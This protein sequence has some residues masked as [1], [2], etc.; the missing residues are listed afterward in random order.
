MRKRKS[1]PGRGYLIC[2]FRP[3]GLGLLFIWPLATV[4]YQA[5]F[6]PSFGIETSSPS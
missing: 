1:D 4:V 3:G 6:E 5:L 2:S